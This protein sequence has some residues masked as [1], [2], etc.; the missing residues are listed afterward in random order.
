[1]QKKKKKSYI[2][3]VYIQMDTYIQWCVNNGTPIANKTI[4]QITINA[5]S[6]TKYTHLNTQS[7]E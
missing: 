1:M 5:L 3:M 2:Q 4:Q 6:Q 7:A